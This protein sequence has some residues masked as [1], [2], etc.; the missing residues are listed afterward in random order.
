MS[1]HILLKR[2]FF[3]MM[4][5][6]SMLIAGTGFIL[7]GSLPHVDGTCEIK[8]L[9][10]TVRI[11][12]DAIGMPTVHGMHRIDVARATGFLHGQERFF[13]MDLLRRNAAGELAEILGPSSLEKDKKHR[14]YQFRQHAQSLFDS[15]TDRGKRDSGSLFGRS[16]PRV[17]CTGNIP[18]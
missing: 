3:S 13:Q 5:I 15:L 16:Q 8:G 9:K 2:I 4:G 14:L 1:K 11:E 10:E 18:F 7:W 17:E 12:R 6:G